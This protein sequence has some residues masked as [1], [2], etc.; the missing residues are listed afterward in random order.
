[1]IHYLF[2][3]IFISNAWDLFTYNQV[4]KLIWQHCFFSVV[5]ARVSFVVLNS[6]FTRRG[7]AVLVLNYLPPGKLLLSPTLPLHFLQ[8]I[9]LTWSVNI[10]YH[11]VM[12]NHY[13]FRLL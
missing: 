1:M 5:Q 3:Q 9:M 4:F 6:Q 8:L 11:S 13:I 10:L 12:M 7:E 2:D